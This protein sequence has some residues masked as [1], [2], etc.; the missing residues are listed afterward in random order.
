MLSLPITNNTP[1]EWETRYD[2]IGVF[3]QSRLKG[4]L[5]NLEPEEEQP[6][7]SARDAGT[8]NRCPTNGL[9]TSRHRHLK[10]VIISKTID[11]NITEHDFSPTEAKHD[12][13]R[14]IRAVLT[15]K[16]NSATLYST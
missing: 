1:L 5:G 15:S 8:S 6:A 2:G 3:V 14:S 13:R 4:N 9:L 10:A 12:F 11:S 7:L 16:S